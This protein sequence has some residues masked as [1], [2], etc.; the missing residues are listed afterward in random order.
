[1]RIVNFLFWSTGSKDMTTADQ[2][3]LKS[4]HYTF[5]QSLIG[6]SAIRSSPLFLS[7]VFKNVFRTAVAN[8]YINL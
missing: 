8:T 6:G 1:M 5:M 4:L 2:R 7:K 3:P